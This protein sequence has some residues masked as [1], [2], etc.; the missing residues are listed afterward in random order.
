MSHLFPVVNEGSVHVEA[1]CIEELMGA[2]RTP[3]MWSDVMRRIV[4]ARA[5]KRR[6]NQCGGPI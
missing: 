3:E 2:L 5:G 1:G 4:A 6:R